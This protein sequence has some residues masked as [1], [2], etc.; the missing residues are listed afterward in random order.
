MLLAPS[1]RGRGP[2]LDR[3]RVA[4]EDEHRLDAVEEQLRHAVERADEVRVLNHVALVVAHGLNELREPD[5]RVHGQH[6]VRERLDLD[7]PPHRREQHPEVL[8]AHTLDLCDGVLSV[9]L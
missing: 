9:L 5:A 3:R 8:H 7:L 6:L 4:V 1:A 2:L